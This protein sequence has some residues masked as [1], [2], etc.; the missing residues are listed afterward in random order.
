MNQ[1][2]A[3]QVAEP[4]FNFMQLAFSGK[5]D[6]SAIPFEEKGSVDLFERLEDM[7]SLTIKE[8][9]ALPS[10]ERRALKELMVQYVMF[11]TMFEDLVFPTSFLIGTDETNLGAPVLDYVA[12]HQWPFPQQLPWTEKP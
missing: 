8:V 7:Q 9:F 2:T 1:L 12:I 6:P 5:H 4:F 3:A 10:S 11:W